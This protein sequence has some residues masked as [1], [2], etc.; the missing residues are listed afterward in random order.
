MFLDTSHNSL[1]TVVANI[2]SAFTETAT[3]MWTYVRC[4]PSGKRPST[5]LLIDT[6]SRVI[7]LAFV[8]MKSK[9]KNKKNAGYVCGVSKVQ[10]EWYV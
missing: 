5:N 7:E 9:G 4:L 2:H 8:L 3:K 10:V 1:A 6:I